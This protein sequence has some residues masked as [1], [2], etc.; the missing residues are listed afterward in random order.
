VLLVKSEALVVPCR[1]SHGRS[2]FPDREG[3]LS[4]LKS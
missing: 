2:S 4:D 1:A 3:T